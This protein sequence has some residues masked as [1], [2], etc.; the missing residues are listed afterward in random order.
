MTSLFYFT[1]KS[2]LQNV[3]NGKHYNNAMRIY[4]ILYSTITCWCIQILQDC[5]GNEDC[6]KLIEGFCISKE[7]N[8]GD[9][10]TE[11]GDAD[12]SDLGKSY[13]LDK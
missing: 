11:E 2:K 4:K 1:E 9:R 5:L 10:D 3:I 6:E 13:V 12:I 8:D 7:L